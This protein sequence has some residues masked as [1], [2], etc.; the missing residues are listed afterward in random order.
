M[1]EVIVA[2]GIVTLVLSGLVSAITYGLTSVQYSRNK[3]LATKYA[4]E[5]VEWVRSKRDASSNWAAFYAL[6]TTPTTYCMQ[7]LSWSVSSPCN[8]IDD[9][10]DKF[11]RT[12]TLT[13]NGNTP[14]NANDRVLVEVV[15]TWNEG[16][17]TSNVNLETYLSSW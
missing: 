12:V 1:V 8:P 13:G 14:P 4:Q 6:G 17:R 5:A 7:T 2:S 15:V 16:R 10:Y 11:V 9:V 3:A